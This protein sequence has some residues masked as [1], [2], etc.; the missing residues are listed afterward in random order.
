MLIKENEE[1]RKAEIDALKMRIDELMKNEELLKKT[2]QDLETD[3]SDKNKVIIQHFLII[4]SIIF[5][6]ICR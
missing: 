3:I 1:T 6:T 5:N 2:I 4:Y